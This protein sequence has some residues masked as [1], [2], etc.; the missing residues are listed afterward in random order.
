MDK[1]EKIKFSVYNSPG[2]SR[3]ITKEVTISNHLYYKV[4]NSSSTSDPELTEWAKKIF[5]DA[6]D[7]KVQSVVF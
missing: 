5:P 3:D 4:S 2:N 7:V 6:H 1:T